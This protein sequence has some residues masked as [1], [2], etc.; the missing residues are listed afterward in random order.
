MGRHAALSA[1]A[2][3]LG[4]AG[5]IEGPPPSDELGEA[6]ASLQSCMTDQD[7]PVGDCTCGV[8]T[9]RCGDE[10]G[11]CSGDQSCYR[12]GDWPYWSHCGGRF[13][14][15]ICLSSCEL[16][17]RDCAAGVCV[18]GVCVGNAVAV[19]ARKFLDEFP[20]GGD[21]P[22]NSPQAVVVEVAAPLCD[23][24]PVLNAPWVLV[25]K[26]VQLDS[27]RGC[28][29]L[30]GDL[31]IGPIEDADLSPLSDLEVVGGTL[32][33]GLSDAFSAFL[34]RRAGAEGEVP[35]RPAYPL[36]GQLSDESPPAAF[37]SLDALSS[38]RQVGGLILAGLRSE[39]LRGL[40]RLE[41]I[42]PRR[43][44]DDTSGRLEIAGAY[45]LQSL[46]GLETLRE[47]AVLHLTRNLLLR[48]F[49]GLRAGTIVSLRL[50]DNARLS[51]LTGPVYGPELE[52]LV[53]SN[54]P[55]LVDLAPLS[56]TASIGT[57]S[58]VQSPLESLQSLSA[59]R[60]AGRVRLAS[61][62]A[63]RSLATLGRLESFESLY[64]S[65]NPRL[66]ALPSFLSLAGGSGPVTLTV[67]RNEIL[68]QGPRLPS[69]SR[70]GRLRVEGNPRLLQLMGFA[71][72]RSAQAIE[73]IG[74]LSLSEL[75]FGGLEQV[76]EAVVVTSNPALSAAQVVA[77][78]RVPSPMR[79]IGG[80]E[81]AVSPLSPC[82][83][84]GDGVCDEPDL[85]MFATDV[86]DCS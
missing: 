16:P 26:Q 29:E 69:V 1:L 47:V 49:R 20:R 63:L 23:S 3:A 80:N 45:R 75:D 85:C 9:P 57:L 44:G 8:C 28:R 58:V 41:R 43:Y 86:E 18:Q 42:G 24:S 65:E 27:L 51:N 64:V 2:V 4:C 33:L 21:A 38:L 22:P 6:I 66:E 15:G 79:K 60:R 71:A 82:P 62:R 53:L 36:P 77:L 46:D 54:N 68:L 11:A 39:S 10:L 12:S 84:T 56:E 19:E 13:I 73:L 17:D 59:L 70:L 61:N 31:L 55:E 14:S 40:R 50:E 74:N 5:L 81:G 7:C 35:A 25:Q 32:N 30:T 37:P 72:V 52:R 78:S 48:S 76:E 83:W 34:A 67:T